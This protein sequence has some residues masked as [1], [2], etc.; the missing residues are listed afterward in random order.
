MHSRCLRACSEGMV[1]RRTDGRT[2]RTHSRTMHP[3][4][5][6]P[7]KPTGSPIRL[8]F[9]SPTANAW[10]SCY[11]RY[12]QTELEATDTLCGAEAT[13]VAQRAQALFDAERRL[14]RSADAHV[15]LGAFVLLVVTGRVLANAGRGERL[16]RVCFN[17]T[18]RSFIRHVCRP[19]HQ[20]GPRHAHRLEHLNFEHFSAGLSAS[21]DAVGA[22]PYRHFFERH[23]ATELLAVVAQADSAWRDARMALQQ[24]AGFTVFKCHW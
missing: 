21:G 14:A 13:E 10:G 22:L 3:I 17:R 1:S 8:A 15:A 7:P 4:A 20:S 2:A 11:M 12:L 18:Y 6:T 24:P 5:L 23:R 19:L 16:E 9:G